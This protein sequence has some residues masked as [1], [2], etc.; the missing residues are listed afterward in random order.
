MPDKSLDTLREL[1]HIHIINTPTPLSDAHQGGFPFL[2]TPPDKFS[3]RGL[4]WADLIALMWA[5]GLAIA[6]Q[7]ECAKALKA[8]GYYR[9]SAYMLPFQKGGGGTQRHDFEPGTDFAQILDLYTFDRQLRLVTVDALERIEVALRTAITDV[10]C[11]SYD[12]FWYV[13]PNRF[14]KSYI[15]RVI[16]TKLDMTLAITTTDRKGLYQLIIIIIVMAAQAYRHLGWFLNH[17]LSGVSYTYLGTWLYLIERKY[18]GN[19]ILTRN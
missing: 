11:T 7:S 13:E 8:I 14:D 18:H 6:D 3:K 1:G 5:R 12:P 17:F 16:L 2:A 4:A 19:L 10:M 15:S 9:L